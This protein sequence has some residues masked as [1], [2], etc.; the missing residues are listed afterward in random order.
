MALWHHPG[1]TRLRAPDRHCTA[2]WAPGEGLILPGALWQGCL[3]RL[4]ICSPN[5]IGASALPNLPTCPGAPP[6]HCLSPVPPG[7]PA[8]SGALGFIVSSGPL[9]GAGLTPGCLEGFRGCPCSG[10]NARCCWSWAF[11]S[12][13]PLLGAPQGSYPGASSLPAHCQPP[14]PGVPLEPTAPPW[15]SLPLCWCPSAAWLQPGRAAPPVPCVCL[16]FPPHQPLQ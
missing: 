4:D 10:S 11:M 5:P 8:S 7:A 1:D 12:A 3:C 15:G 13:L 6:R 14:E 2:S 16:E 9:D